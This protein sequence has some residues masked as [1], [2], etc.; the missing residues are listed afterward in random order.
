MEIGHVLVATTTAVIPVL[1]EAV[2]SLQL[3]SR[4]KRDKI[5]VDEAGMKGGSWFEV[6]KH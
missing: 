5:L 3:L 6:V 4:T 1:R 2:A